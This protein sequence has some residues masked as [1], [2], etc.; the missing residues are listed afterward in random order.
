MRH[1]W[2]ALP[3]SMQGLCAGDAVGLVGPVLDAVRPG[4]VVMVKGSNASKVSAVA[5]ALKESGGKESR[6]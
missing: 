1:L 6:A 2:D 3:P 4:D 5:R